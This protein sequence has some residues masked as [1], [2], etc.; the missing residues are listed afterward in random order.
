MALATFNSIRG[1]KQ[2]TALLMVKKNPL[3]RSGSPAYVALAG[4][5]HF[6]GK[7]L[8]DEDKGLSFEI[9][10]GFRFVGI[11]G[12]DGAPAMTRPTDG[13]EPVQLMELVY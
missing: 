6:A 4:A 7:K 3:E 11:I 5:E 10:D 8:T 2:T 12:E 13:T 9:P 1:Q